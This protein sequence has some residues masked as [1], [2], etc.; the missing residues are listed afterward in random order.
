MA[1]KPPRRGTTGK[2]GSVQSEGPTALPTLPM[3][4]YRREIFINLC[5]RIVMAMRDV[6]GVAL[7]GAGLRSANCRY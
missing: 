4:L 6:V 2:N 3:E 1:Q 7:T 5:M